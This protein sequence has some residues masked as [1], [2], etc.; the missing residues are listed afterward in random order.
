M[1]ALLANSVELGTVDLIII[2]AVV[3]ALLVFLGKRISKLMAW[4]R[5]YTLY[6]HTKYAYG[7]EASSYESRKSDKFIVYKKLYYDWKDFRNK[8][9]FSL[10]VLIIINFIIFAGILIGGSWFLAEKVFPTLPSLGLDITLGYVISSSLM[11]LLGFLFCWTPFATFYY[12]LFFPI[13]LI[14]KALSNKD[15]L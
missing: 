5:G 14:I 7:D 11:N 6:F 4:K 9:Y 8:N 1:G 12:T 3:L 15:K 10:I 2:G 13:H